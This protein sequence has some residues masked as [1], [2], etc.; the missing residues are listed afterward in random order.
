MSY[1]IS[2]RTLDPRLMDI[3]VSEAEGM[4]RLVRG[5]DA[6]DESDLAEVF[7]D[8]AFILPGQVVEDIET[9]PIL[10]MSKH[11][12]LIFD[13][14]IVF[15]GKPQ[16]GRDREVGR[17]FFDQLNNLNIP[18]RGDWKHRISH[19]DQ[20][21]G[22]IAEEVRH[23][24]ISETAA[25]EAKSSGDQLRLL[26]LGDRSHTTDA[27]DRDKTHSRKQIHWKLL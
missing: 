18:A 15:N 23:V 3:A 13:K 24:L 1:Q 26:C 16:P 17:V 19:H 4:F 21:D 10:T 7:R 9:L 25:H 14:E 22:L 8:R 11:K 27:E 2:V 20:C 5:L 12:A 6:T